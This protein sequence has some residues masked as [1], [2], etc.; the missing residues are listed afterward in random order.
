MPIR[1]FNSLLRWLHLY[2]SMFG[3]AAL[4]FFAFT[5]ITLNHPGWT[6]GKQKISSYSGTIDQSLISV[7]NSA[8]ADTVKI[9]ELIRKNHQIRGRVTDFRIDETEC[10]ISFTGPG[11]RADVFID[12]S[13]GSYEVT[14]TS[15]GFVTAL[16]DLHKGRDTGP[17]WSRVM[18]I[19]AIIMMIV[20]ITG[21]LMIFYICRKKKPGLIV[22]IIGA[23]TFIALCIL[24]N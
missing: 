16:N 6:E 1:N 18:D 22:A 9:S 7:D 20:S 4:F 2:L 23:L 24:L 14:A 3:F 10:S 12:R 11:Y 15:A 17:G 19:S 21:F 5:G 8:P 13:S